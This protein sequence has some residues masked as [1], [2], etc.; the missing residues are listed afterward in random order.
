MHQPEIAAYARFA[1]MTIVSGDAR[2]WLHLSLSAGQLQFA[3]RS[4]REH[5]LTTCFLAI[6]GRRTISGRSR[7][8]EMVMEY[9]SELRIDESDVV[10][11]PIEAFNRSSVQLFMRAVAAMHPDHRRLVTV[12]FTVG[13]WAGSGFAPVRG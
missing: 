12:P 6:P 10:H 1:S 11:G 8:R 2:G 3:N 13:W 5:H 4:N 7:P 9:A